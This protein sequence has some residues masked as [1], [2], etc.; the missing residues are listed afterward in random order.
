MASWSPARLT[1]QSRGATSR[2][3]KHGGW[4]SAKVVRGV[5]YTVKGCILRAIQT[6]KAWWAQSVQMKFMT[7]SRAKF[8]KKSGNS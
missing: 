3:Q 1:W 7:Y 8:G 6:A 2:R 5:V 4:Q